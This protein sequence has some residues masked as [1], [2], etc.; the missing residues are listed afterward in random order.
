MDAISQFRITCWPSQL[1]HPGFSA[2]KYRLIPELD[3]F[4]VDSDAG[5]VEPQQVTGETYLELCAVDLDDTAS[6]ERFVDR[7]GLLEL[8]YSDHQGIGEKPMFGFFMHPGWETVS[9]E[10]DA[11]LER[12]VTGLQQLDDDVKAG[13][14][15]VCPVSEFR[16][17]AR[18][19]RDLVTA[20][21]VVRG[22]LALADASWESPVWQYDADLPYKEYPWMPGRESDDP[23]GA[24]SLLDSYLSDGLETFSP[25]VS[26]R[27]PKQS[28]DHLL[29]HDGTLWEKLCLELFNHL[30]GQTAYKLCANE[31]CGRLFVRQA[32]RSKHGQY[33]S[34]GVKFCSALCAKAQ[35]N[36]DY[37]RRKAGH[38]GG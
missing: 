3:A 32:G 6:I 29:E 16:Y 36:R 18:C 23:G 25:V 28:E 17:G 33:R 4:V 7:Y 2:L 12:A 37:R 22:E 8:R 5:W 26:T 9:A 27:G 10:L 1:P 35:A 14:M 31:R 21:R 38:V 19:M 34:H 30:A 15:E 20:A 24:A 11:D 13:I